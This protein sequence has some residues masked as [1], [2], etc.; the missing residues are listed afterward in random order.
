MVGSIQTSITTLEELG[1][2]TYIAW[3]PGHAEL[4]PNELA[5]R[6]AKE[7]AKQASTWN[8]DQD[9]STKLLSQTR[10]EIRSNILKV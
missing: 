5:D 10:R 1:I 4:K 9:L 6:A 3:V 8:M 7:A 2:S